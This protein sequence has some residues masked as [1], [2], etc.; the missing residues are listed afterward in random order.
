MNKGKFGIALP[1]YAVVAMILAIFGQVIPLLGLTIFVIAVEK[2]EWA[3]RQCIQ[4][5]FVVVLGWVADKAVYILKEPLVNWV[6][7][8]FYN[9]GFSRFAGYYGHSL[10]VLSSAF[11]VFLLVLLV[12]AVFKVARGAEAN[13]MI[14]TKFADW[15]FGKVA[16]KPQPVYQQPMQQVQQ[17]QQ[18]V[19]PQQPVQMA[20]PQAQAPAG[21]FCVKCGAPLSGAFCEKCGTKN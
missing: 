15:A 3:S 18:P 11:G 16:P 17:V 14:A 21:K 12:I 13:I 7:G 2:D 20:Q 10:T 8:Y 1:F 9:D 6:G 5:F 19:Q 4:A